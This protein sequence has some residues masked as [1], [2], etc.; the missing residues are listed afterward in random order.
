MQG[1][2]VGSRHFRQIFSQLPGC[3]L[4]SH[5]AEGSEG[6]FSNRCPI[7]YQ[8]GSTQSLE[9]LAQYGGHSGIVVCASNT[10]L[11]YAALEL[12]FFSVLLET[13]WE[14]HAAVILDRCLSH[15]HL[16][17]NQQ[18]KDESHQSLP[19]RELLHDLNNAISIMIGKHQ[20][21][22]QEPLNATALEHVEHSLEAGRHANAI[23]KQFTA[24]RSQQKQTQAMTD[25]VYTT[26]RAV[27]LLQNSL[28]SSIELQMQLPEGG[29]VIPLSGAAYTRVLFNLLLNARDA[30]PEG[31]LLHLSIDNGWHPDQ[32]FI[33]TAVLR[34]SDTGSGIPAELQ[35]H[36]FDP[37]YTTK[38][39]QGTGLGLSAVQTLINRCGGRVLCHS[40]PLQGTTFEL[41]FPLVEQPPL[42]KVLWLD[43]QSQWTTDT[44]KILHQGGFEIVRIS[45]SDELK[46]G[47]NQSDSVCAIVMDAD[48]IE[49]VD[50]L[51]LQMKIDKPPIKI[52]LIQSRQNKK[53]TSDYPMLTAPFSPEDLLQ[54]LQNVVA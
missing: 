7:L 44:D 11:Y 1:Y 5:P 10:D 16:A 22:K 41:H 53:N 20:L 12:G 18:D 35:K 46:Q 26:K 8:C 50:P 30:M 45:K 14:G 51:I 6:I 48:L 29:Q 34:V 24:Q 28:S 38:G 25:I 42:Q 21:L 2:L 39:E 32:Y 52:L 33:A 3:H 4:E 40:N 19:I 13:G 36:I 47:L 54:S 31:G 49:Q 43:S 27:H 37:F 9:S 15:A 23:F 17:L